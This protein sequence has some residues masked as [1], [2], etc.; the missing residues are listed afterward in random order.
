MFQCTS[1]FFVD[2]TARQ[3]H[4]ST[5]L[6]T[7]VMNEF[8]TADRSCTT[9]YFWKKILQKLV[10]HIFMLLFAPFDSKLVN[11]S[12]RS[13]TLNFRKNS[14]LTTFW[15]QFDHFQTFFKDS[16]CLQKLTNF[17]AKGVKR[18][19]KMGAT[20][21]YKIFFKNILLYM[22]GRGQKFVQYICME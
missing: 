16:L 10:A 22:N 8:L 20:N 3:K 13:E 17:D 11:Y 21:F 18:S 12:R 15:Q 6:H 19:V 7:Y 2:C 4:E 5:F 14:K 1:N 9:K